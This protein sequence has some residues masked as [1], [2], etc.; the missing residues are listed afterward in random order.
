MLRTFGINQWGSFSAIVHSKLLWKTTK[1][2]QWMPQVEC[3]TDLCLNFWTSQEILIAI[4]KWKSQDVVTGNTGQCAVI[5]EYDR[6][7]S[8][9]FRVVD[10]WDCFNILFW[11][12]S[13]IWLVLQMPV[14]IATK[15]LRFQVAWPKKKDES[16]TKTTWRIALGDSWH[17]D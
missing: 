10:Q 16:E 1:L 14:T 9:K 15:F 5:L 13:S 6:T 4:M 17:A 12:Y 11:F 3:L 2:N 8:K 7:W